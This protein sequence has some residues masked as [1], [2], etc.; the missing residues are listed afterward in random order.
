[1]PLKKSHVQSFES[2]I[3][4]YYFNMYV[5]QGNSHHLEIQHLKNCIHSI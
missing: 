3:I 5:I 4:S 1:M 2:A